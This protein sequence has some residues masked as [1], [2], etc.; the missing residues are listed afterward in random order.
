MM[1]RHY[2]VSLLTLATLYSAVIAL[3]QL[4]KGL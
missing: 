1:T 4:T 2:F 3:T